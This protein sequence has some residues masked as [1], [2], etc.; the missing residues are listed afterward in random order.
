MKASFQSVDVWRLDRHLI[1]FLLLITENMR[2][3]FYKWL[4]AARTARN[5][6]VVLQENEKEMQ[7]YRL[8][9]AWDKWRGRFQGE[10]LRPI[11]RTW[12]VEF[13]SSPC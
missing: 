6:R 5:R 8:A 10:R 9:A 4:A 1:I 13:R 2:R 3:M 11:V 12:T 7:R